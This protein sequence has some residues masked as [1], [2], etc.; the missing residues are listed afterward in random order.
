MTWMI[1]MHLSMHYPEKFQK[2]VYHPYCAAKHKNEGGDNTTIIPKQSKT[3]IRSL[4]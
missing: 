4:Y 3:R 2:V 1:Q